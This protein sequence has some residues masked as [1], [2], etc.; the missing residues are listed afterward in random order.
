[1]LFA[2]LIIIVLVIF[3]CLFFVYIVAEPHP[4][5]ERHE[6]EMFFVDP[7]NNNKKSRFLHNIDAASIDL[8]VV[9]PAYNEEERMPQMLNEAIAFLNK[10]QKSNP[11]FTYEIIIVDDGS[12]DNTTKTGLLYVGKYGVDKVRVLTLEKNRGKGG[13]IRLGVLSSRGR[14]ILF[15]DADGAT[16]FSDL[17][18]L[19]KKLEQEVR[20]TPSNLVVICGSR[21][22]LEKESI[23]TRTYFR[24]ILMYGFHFVV[25]FLCVRGVKDTQCGFKLLSREAA[26]L[27]FR[28]LHVERWAFDVDILYLAQYFKMTIAEVAVTWEEIEGSKLVPFWSWLQMG[29]D[30]FLIWLHYSIGAWR[31]NSKRKVT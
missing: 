17:G 27:L 16:K 2:G 10:R 21:A 28:N 31:I 9:V 7:K 24:T 23:A 30:L 5:L 4:S 19:E 26:L 18:K 29:K 22:H 11:A 20:K 25:W 14:R 12:N 1:M 6:S 8:T 13:A 15:A 3:I